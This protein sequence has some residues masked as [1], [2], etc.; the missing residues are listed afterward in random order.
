MKIKIDYISDIVCPWCAIGFYRLEKAIAEL[1]LENK[2]E[3]EWQPFQLNPSLSLQGQNLQEHISEKYNTSQE[4]Y[5]T[6]QEKLTEA[7]EDE[8]IVFDFF[9][10]M[11]IQNTKKAHLLLHY[12]KKNGKQT[13]LSKS[14]IKAHFSERKNISENETLMSVLT[15][16]G[17]DPIAALKKL[18]DNTLINKFEEKEASWKNLGVKSVPTIIFNRK[19]A[20]SG[21]QPK[22]TFK[23]VLKQMIEEQS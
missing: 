9:D 4:E 20:L 11:K 16:V 19:T 8:G 12:A 2:V 15:L 10:G 14:L 22:S 18:S 5:L 6:S 1:G 17:L 7:A 23:E 3:I 13:E 21:A